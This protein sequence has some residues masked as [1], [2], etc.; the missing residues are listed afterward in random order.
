MRRTNLRSRIAS[1]F[2]ASIV[3]FL[4][5]ALM[6]SPVYAAEL[7]V[8]DR[9]MVAGSTVSP[10]GGIGRYENLAVQSENLGTTWTASGAIVTVNQENG[11]NDSINTADNVDF[12]ATDTNSVKQTI[13]STLNASSVYTLSV[14]A[15]AGSGSPKFRFVLSNDGSTNTFSADQTTSTSWQRFSVTLPSGTPN[16]SNY[17]GLANGSTGTNNGVRFW[18][19]QLEKASSPGV[20]VRTTT[21]SVAA[22]KG[23]VT[24]GSPTDTGPGT[25]AVITYRLMGVAIPKTAVDGGAIIP[26]DGTIVSVNLYREVA[27]TSLN[28]IVDVNKNGTTIFTGQANRPT[29]V[30]NSSSKKVTV[31]TIDIA[32]VSAGD[33][34]TCDIDQ[35]DGGNPEDIVVTVE[36]KKN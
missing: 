17:V 32:S 26:F 5:C 9:L 22:S 21:S 33:V 25:R 1:A 12:G 23:T 8:L 10:F 15:K 20:Y 6:S 13:N 11:P 19:F 30:F 7:E 28:T 27:G 14:W 16:A 35:V 24:D 36:L 18:G 3:G 4:S 31:T 2:L 34:L 29:L